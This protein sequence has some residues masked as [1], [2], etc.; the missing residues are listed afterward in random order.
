MLDVTHTSEIVRTTLVDLFAKNCRSLPQNGR[1]SIS[2]HPNR[3]IVYKDEDFNELFDVYHRVN[4]RIVEKHDRHGVHIDD[5]P[6]IVEE[7]LFADMEFNDSA[8]TG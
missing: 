3:V 4:G 5:L 7:F 6:A 1:L 2:K 8:K